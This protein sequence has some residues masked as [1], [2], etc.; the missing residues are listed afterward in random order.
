M[1]QP[2]NQPTNQRTN[3]PNKQRKTKE[4]SPP[5]ITTPPFLRMKGLGR[6]LYLS[7][8]GGGIEAKNAEKG[9]K[10]FPWSK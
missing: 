5:A 10:R 9:K 3:Q 2:T 6:A 4:N 1:N 8:D 7:K